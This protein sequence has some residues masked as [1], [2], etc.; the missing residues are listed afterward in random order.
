GRRVDAGV[1]ERQ[2]ETEQHVGDAGADQEAA[3]HYAE[4]DRTHGQ[5]FDPAV[6]G[7]QLGVRQVLGEDAVLGR[8]IGGRAQADQRVGGERIDVEQHQR[9]AGDLDGV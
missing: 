2:V 8:R 1:D 3:E 7:H 4:D 9:A 6:G 5:A